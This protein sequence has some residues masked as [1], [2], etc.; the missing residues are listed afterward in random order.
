MLRVMSESDS[1]PEPVK[2]SRVVR[3][4][5]S[6]HYRNYHVDGAFTS[7][8]QQ[9]E[10]YLGFYSDRSQVTPKMFIERTPEGNRYR[11]DP[12]GHDDEILR[13]IECGLYLSFPVIIGLR[14][15][16]DSRIQEFIK[17]YDLAPKPQSG[18]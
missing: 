9:G 5:H 7:V 17:T 3:Q 8:T 15:L 11:Q 13:E 10:I 4:V 6:A 12:S 2:E 1:A 18:E 14:D 16:L